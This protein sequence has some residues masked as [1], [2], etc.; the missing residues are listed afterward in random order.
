MQ[1]TYNGKVVIIEWL[2][3]RENKSPVSHRFSEKPIKLQL[4]PYPDEKDKVIR[5]HF[6]GE[7]PGWI[8][9]Y[10]SKHFYRSQQVIIDGQVGWWI[11]KWKGYSQNPFSSP[12]IKGAV[13]Q[14]AGQIPYEV[15]ELRRKLLE[16]LETVVTNL[17]FYPD[18][19]QQYG[20]Y[21]RQEELLHAG[22][23]LLLED[24]TIPEKTEGIDKEEYRDAIEASKLPDLIWELTE[25]R[26]IPELNEEED[27]STMSLSDEEVDENFVIDLDPLE[28]EDE[29]EIEFTQE[30]AEAEEITPLDEIEK[31]FED[32]TIII[33]EEDEEEQEETETILLIE[34]ESLDVDKSEETEKEQEHKQDEKGNS[35]EGEKYDET[36]DVNQTLT[37]D[38][39]SQEVDEKPKEEKIASSKGEK[40]AKKADKKNKIVEGQFFLF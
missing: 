37:L 13:T 5:A 32:E 26:A 9:S 38:Q 15:D 25:P 4:H 23:C 28:E 40:V 33:L 35:T 2:E 3:K 6:K 39:V 21:F 27:E 19:Y 11:S 8:E 16:N 30:D 24:G 31:D 20:L 17:R 29:Q 34:E 10:C 12:D 7:R 18:D 22:G 14:L 1:P 36:N